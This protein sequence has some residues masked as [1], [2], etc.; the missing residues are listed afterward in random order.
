MFH[1][2]FQIVV[3]LLPSTR[4]G[5][6]RAMNAV[7]LAIG[8]SH[9][10]LNVPN[11]TLQFVRQQLHEA[12]VYLEA[13]AEAFREFHQA[14]NRLNRPRQQ[15]HG[16]PQQHQ[17]QEQPA[18]QQQEPHHDPPDAE[19]EEQEPEPDENV[20]APMNDPG[21][22]EEQLPELEGDVK[23]EV[24]KPRQATRIETLLHLHRL[25]KQMQKYK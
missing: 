25:N 4:D 14:P 5:T 23:A 2:H 17:A 3:D 12:M 11:E 13:A 19:P 15:D 7:I 20:P 10:A 16:A 18:P 22:E 24:P 8:H 21:R 6:Q 9:P 1:S